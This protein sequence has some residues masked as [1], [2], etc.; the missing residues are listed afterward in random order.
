MQDLYFSRYRGVKMWQ[1]Y[2]RQTLN[3]TAQLPCA[4]GHIRTFFGRRKDHATHAEGFS[5]EPQANTTYATNLALHRLWADPLNRI[6]INGK[7]QLRIEPL[8]HVHDAL[9]GQFY[10]ADVDFAIERIKDWFNNE[11]VIAGRTITIPFEGQYGPSWGCLGPK[12]GGGNI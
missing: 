8:H 1:E 5:H 10:R 9:C 3:N 7:T 6:S 11:L 4:S 12:Y 2:I